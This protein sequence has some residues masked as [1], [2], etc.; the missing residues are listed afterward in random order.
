MR[1]SCWY[2]LKAS[3]NAEEANNLLNKPAVIALL[4]AGSGFRFKGSASLVLLEEILASVKLGL[5]WGIDAY[6]NAHL[7]AVVGIF[8]VVV[9]LYMKQGL[10]GLLVARE[11]RG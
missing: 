6:I 10:F 4:V 11:R 8:I 9:A 3:L 7:M 1:S 5:P 2:C